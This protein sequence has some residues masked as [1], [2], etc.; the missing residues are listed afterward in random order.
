[1]FGEVEYEPS[2]SY[3]SVPLEEQLQ[4]LDSAVR[5]GK[6]RHVGLSNETAWGLMRCCTL[7]TR[8]LDLERWSLPL[9]SC[10]LHK[11]LFCMGAADAQ[12]LP[13]VI[14]LQNAY[15]LLCRTFDSTL[16]ECCHKEGVS[17]LAYSPLAMGLLTVR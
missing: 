16:A 1:M 2:R 4:A 8:L 6:V 7:G 14:S 11:S 15:N 10:A 13:Q 17:L 12:G 5:M 9:L 3:S